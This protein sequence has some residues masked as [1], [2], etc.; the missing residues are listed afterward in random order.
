MSATTGPEH[1]DS[2]TRSRYVATIVGGKVLPSTCVR[3][4]FDVLD[5]AGVS[6]EVRSGV[7]WPLTTPT[8]P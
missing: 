2:T 4:G 8:G 3:E 6:A 1:T 5:A 7:C